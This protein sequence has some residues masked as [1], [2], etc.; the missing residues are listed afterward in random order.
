MKEIDLRI[1]FQDQ[2]IYL[3]K[4]CIIHIDVFIHII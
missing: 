1:I 3:D 4:N 2:K